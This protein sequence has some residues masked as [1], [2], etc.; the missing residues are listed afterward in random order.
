MSAIV[1]DRV[2][3]YGAAAVGAIAVQY[4]SRDSVETVLKL[5]LHVLAQKYSCDVLHLYSVNV[6]LNQFTLRVIS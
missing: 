5:T 6:L 2:E 3:R 1:A 4:F